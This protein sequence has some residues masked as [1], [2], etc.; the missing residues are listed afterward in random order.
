MDAK[1][2][3]V[4]PPTPVSPSGSVPFTFRAEGSIGIMLKAGK[5]KKVLVKSVEA[6][7][8]A[9]AQ[10]VPPEAHLVAVNDK[11][12]SGLAAQTILKLVG[13]PERPLTLHFML[14]TSAVEQA[15][16]AQEAY[17]DS[18]AACAAV[19]PTS[20]S[21]PA[22]TPT[23][24]GAK[25]KVNLTGE[26]NIASRP[27]DAAL[28]VAALEKYKAA[29]AAAEASEGGSSP[30]G[31]P[32]S[33]KD[34]IPKGAGFGGS[35]ASVESAAPTAAPASDPPEPDPEPE[36]EP[37]AASVATPVASVATPVAGSAKPVRSRSFGLKNPF[38]RKKAAK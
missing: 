6:G 34:L 29:K 8:A 3:E 7:S 16:A 38:S 9:E 37:V 19:S 22:P 33:S 17:R 32:I 35:S 12:V 23:S 13:S 27:G 31:A 26:C 20:S 1:L 11:L 18:K 2:P 30:G 10:D 28:T 25:E 4:E 14:P 36:P 15:G 5:D 21:A 24:P